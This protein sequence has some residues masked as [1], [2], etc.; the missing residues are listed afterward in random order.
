MLKGGQKGDKT[1]ILNHCKIVQRDKKTAIF[2]KKCFYVGRKS[3]NKSTLKQ[4]LFL[5]LFINYQI[6][7]FVL[8]VKLNK[9]RVCA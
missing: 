3:H 9:K 7:I 6:F 1:L 5:Y 2:P 8:P 4:P